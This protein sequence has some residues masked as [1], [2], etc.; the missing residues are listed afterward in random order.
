MLHLVFAIAGSIRTDEP[1][2][3]RIIHAHALGMFGGERLRHLAS[4]IDG[5]GRIATGPSVVKVTS[6]PS[7]TFGPVRIARGLPDFRRTEMRSIRI[8]I[9]DA[10]HDGKVAAVVKRLQPGQTWMQSQGVVDL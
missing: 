2:V 6:K 10:L 7:V 8:R 9:T 1:I 3:L 5:D 4:D